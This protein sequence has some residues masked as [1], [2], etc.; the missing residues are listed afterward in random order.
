MNMAPLRGA[1]DASP[2]KGATSVAP[3][4]WSHGVR[5]LNSLCAAGV[6]VLK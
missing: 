6:G 5:L 1:C 2:L 3:Q 4:S